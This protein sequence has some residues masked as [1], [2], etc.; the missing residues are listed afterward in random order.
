MWHLVKILNKNSTNNTNLIQSTCFLNYNSFS[1]Y[2]K[3]N[4]NN[5]V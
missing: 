5:Y 4:N 1:L 3:F 2:Y